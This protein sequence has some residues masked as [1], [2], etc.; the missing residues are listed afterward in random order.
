MSDL[1]GAVP[2][3]FLQQKNARPVN[4][5]EL[6]MMGKRAAALYQNSG[7]DLTEAVIEI[8][9][10]ARLAPEQVK[11]VCE[12]AN[13][14]AY[15]NEFEKGGEVRN[16]TF[17]GGPADPGRAL[18]DLNDGS[19]P[20]LSYEENSDYSTPTGSYKTAGRDMSKLASA[21]GVAESDL[22]KTAEATR[23]HYSLHAN[24]I[25]DVYD[26]KVALE[27]VREDALSKLA[28]SGVIYRDVADD[29]CGAAT[30]EVLNGT[31]LG[32]VARACASFTRDGDLAK[33]AMVE[34]GKHLELYMSREERG[35]S[36]A[37]V[38]SAGVIPDPKH[39]VVERFVAFTK[40]ADGHRRLQMSVDVVNE[41]LQK[42]NQKLRSML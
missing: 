27:A 40:V 21:F 11:R 35:R 23:E 2:L 14:T 8:V 10:E 9:K 12:F 1:Q 39:P 18:R 16:V 30:Q 25:E 32:D 28:S 20:M 3:A 37:K 41:E 38:A 13:T 31:S 6:E 42:V 26:L 24:P 7:T 29:F 17:E 4:P 36:L 33:L 19:N 34:L 15:L 5:E 22:E